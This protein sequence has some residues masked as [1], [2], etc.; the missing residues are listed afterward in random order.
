[1]ADVDGDGSADAVGFGSNGV[2][3]ALSSGSSFASAT[4][5]WT[6]AFSNNGGWRVDSHPRMAADVNG[7]GAAD[8]LGFG[9]DG[10]YAALAE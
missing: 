9:L 10:I 2:Y 6:S 3:V 4:S 8:V 1:M 5:Q 7:D